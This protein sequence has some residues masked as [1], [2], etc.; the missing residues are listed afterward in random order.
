MKNKK[1]TKKK[2]L[3]GVILYTLLYTIPK[4]HVPGKMGRKNI[5][6]ALKK[7][8]TIFYNENEK[9]YLNLI[10][11][12]DKIIDE[13]HEYMLS[14]SPDF[15]WVNPGAVVKLI[16]SKYNEHIDI[17][18]LKESWIQNM[19]KS[20][21]NDEVKNTFISIRYTNKLVDKINNYI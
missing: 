1:N 10:S 3:M 12:A 9:E 2:I 15:R 21:I 20:Y 13:T 19:V 11:I 17:F 18:G 7:Q 14:I 4:N 8:L 6:K 5:L 16:F